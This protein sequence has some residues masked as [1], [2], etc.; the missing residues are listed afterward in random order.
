MNEV[1][2]YIKVFFSTVGSTYD[3]AVQLIYKLLGKYHL[4]RQTHHT[5]IVQ[6]TPLA[7][8]DLVCPSHGTSDI[9]L[10]GSTDRDYEM[11]LLQTTT[12]NLRT[13]VGLFAS[14]IEKRAFRIR[15]GQW[16]MWAVQEVEGLDVVSI[17]LADVMLC[18]VASPM[19]MRVIEADVVQKAALRG[20]PWRDQH[21]ANAMAMVV[22]VGRQTCWQMTRRITRQVTG[23]GEV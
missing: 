1:K 3:A 9:I 14:K 16:S 6:G 20:G 13:W 12:I 19:Q 23:V 10:R 15:H 4:I 5:H 2:I 8:R 7:Y 21:G 11:E 17:K 18:E 22:W